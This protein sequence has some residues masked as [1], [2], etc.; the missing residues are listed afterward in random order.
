MGP[1]E[2]MKSK[3]KGSPSP[4]NISS[5]KNSYLPSSAMGDQ[6]DHHPPTPRDF[7]LSL[8]T[9]QRNETLNLLPPASDRPINILPE[10][11]L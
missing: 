11:L 7:Y 9:S 4:S 2:C 10:Y 1:K 5:A 8:E 6:F 3:N